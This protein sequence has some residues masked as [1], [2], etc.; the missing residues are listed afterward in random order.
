M[1][2]RIEE[3]I[4]QD[5]WQSSHGPMWGWKARALNLGTDEQVFIALNSK[6]GNELKPGTEFEFSPNGKTVGVYMSGKREQANGQRPNPYGGGSTKPAPKPASGP[7]NAP[8]GHS[9]ALT[10]TEYGQ[11]WAAIFPRSYAMMKR[12]ADEGVTPDAIFLKAGDFTTGVMIGKKQG[13]IVDD[14]TA[15]QVEAEAARV[16]KELADA[17]AVID[18]ARAKLETKAPGYAP[19][20]DPEDDGGIPF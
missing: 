17:Q 4:E 3:I 19:S 7:A 5:E 13:E 9:H 18:A 12:L 14:P 1:L 16:A 11:A 20:V 2:V 15:A 6:P 10:V 8:Q